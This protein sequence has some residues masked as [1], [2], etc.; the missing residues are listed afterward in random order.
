MR[1]LHIENVH[2]N[3]NSGTEPAC[4]ELIEVSKWQASTPRTRQ[5]IPAF[6]PNHPAVPKP[7]TKI[8]FS[9]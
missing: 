3:R 4:T 2:Q 6:E 5:S 1:N 8:I 7:V 9:L